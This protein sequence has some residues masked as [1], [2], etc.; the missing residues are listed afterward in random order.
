[1]GLPPRARTQGK[2]R[3]LT[4]S[5]TASLG[6]SQKEFQ[7]QYEYHLKLQGEARSMRGE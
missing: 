6:M 2:G 4:T 1:M 7:K 3:G 5:L